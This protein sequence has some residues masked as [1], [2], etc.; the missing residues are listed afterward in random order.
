MASP[1]GLNA[2]LGFAAETTYGTAVAVTRF[3]PFTSESIEATPDFLESQG[4]I[5]G[6]QIINSNQWTHGV[7]RIG[8]DIAMEMLTR[9][10]GLLL[11]HA[12]G[13]ITTSSSAGTSTHTITPGD[14]GGLGLTVQVGRP[15]GVAGVVQPFTYAGVKI[16]SW[17]L[18]VAA[19]ENAT[20]GLT[21]AAQTHTT[22]TT[23]ATA[24]YLTTGAPFSFANGSFVLA[25]STLCVRSAR[26]AGDNQLD[27]DRVCVGHNYI[28]EPVVSE[29]REFTGEMELEFPDLVHY[30]RFV[31]GT[32]GTLNLLLSN[33]T[34]SIR[35]VGNVR[36]DSYPVTVNDRGLVVSTAAFKCT[37]SVVGNNGSALTITYVTADTTP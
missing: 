6:Q 18:A 9:Q 22:A 28:E 15:S 2:Q 35:A 4:I 31:A 16:A 13:S 36:T 33:G 26:I 21:V 29:Y 34:S 5:A 3:V 24:T 12:L 23:L 30:N 14:L 8:G 17:E 37:A 10:H 20:F 1:S 27:T 19:T 11:H 32:E 7:W 25:S